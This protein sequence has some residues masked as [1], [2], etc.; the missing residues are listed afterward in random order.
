MEFLGRCQVS[1]PRMLSLTTDHAHRELMRPLG[2]LLKQESP[3]SLAREFVWRARRGWDKKRIL[4]RMDDP[5]P[6]EFRPIRYYSP[7]I[8]EFAPE[9][10]A[11]VVGFA[12]EICDGRFPF[13]G[14]GTI[15]LGFPPPWNLD[16]VS[17]LHWPQ[18]LVEGR[19][20]VRH[21]GSDVKVPW[22]LSRLQFLPV[23]GK[24]HVLTGE[25]RYREA[26][27]LLT[28]DWIARNPVGV[29]VN[30]T[31]AM[32]ASLRAVSI[33]F[34]LDLLWPLPLEDQGWLKNI[35]ACLWQHLM[36]IEAHLE[37]SHFVRSNHYLSNIVGLYCLSLFLDGRGMAAKRRIYKRRI[38]REILRQV[39]E[40]GGDYES[41][42]GYHVLVTQ[43]FTTSLLLMRAT[44]A[45]P[46]A[47]FI[48]RLRMMHNFARQLA[49]SEGELPHVGDCDDGRVELLT[50][51]LRQLL[52]VSVPERNSLRVSNLL[53]LG[54][55]LF[56]EHSHAAE[57]AKWYGLSE[58]TFA[59][60]K[61]VATRP[62]GAI[63][64]PR[65]G[66]AI[67]RRRD[68]EILFVA[69]PN[70]ISGKGS[71]SHND[72]L[73]LIMRVGGEEILCDSGTCCYTRDA[74]TRN[75]FRSSTAHNTVIVDE[76]EQN[77]F[78][79]EEQ[80]LFC[81]ENVAQASAIEV[82]QDGGTYTFHS[83][84][85]GYRGMGV[86]HSRTVR[87]TDTNRVIV[88]DEITGDGVHRFEA[89]WHLNSTY[90]VEAIETVEHGVCC[91]IQGATAMVM[92]FSAPVT[93]Q[94]ESRPGSLS[95]V[96]GSSVRS[97]HIRVRGECGLPVTLF[98][99]IFE[100]D[101]VRNLLN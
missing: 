47:E 86:T 1:V 51:D 95:R 23:L 7:R 49:N 3:V 64:F 18:T 56:G 38:E 80:F 66:I 79:L 70:S 14:Y 101:N 40:D 90:R 65:S 22:E 27:K 57:D 88:E 82:K 13:L 12:S 92:E 44:K 33:C 17:G 41:S 42:L 19:N 2:Q 85:S 37:F 100:A 50:D 97:C 39:H 4:A 31:L 99:R 77:P 46:S 10:R 21:D 61:S 71:H 54:A 34:L 9:T 62:D 63:V 15:P 55:A 43:M 96:Y 26:A 8:K 84:H 30:W 25:K 76:K 74:T 58:D 87:L 89:N 59:T 35:T 11:S 68:T 91:Q 36:F 81:M 53:G 78:S 20:Y 69:M 72:K 16:F 32:E 29:G 45:T 83:S 73:S 6:V 48:E 98:T 75:R 94:V 24:A 52:F 28:S 5:C 67:A 93:L 60:P